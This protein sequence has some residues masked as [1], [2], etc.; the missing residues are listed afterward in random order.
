MTDQHE[1]N[2]AEKV[3]QINEAKK[4]KEKGIVNSNPIDVNTLTEYAYGTAFVDNKWFTVEVKFNPETKEAI[5]TQLME[6][7][8]KTGSTEKLKIC[9]SN[10]VSGFQAI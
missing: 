8:G 1:I 7:D 6:A 2:I 9:V 5:V 3:R 4:N 10:F